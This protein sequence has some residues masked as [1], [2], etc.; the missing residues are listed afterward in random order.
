MIV[1]APGIAVGLVS[2]AIGVAYRRSQRQ[3]REDRRNELHRQ[4]WRIASNDSAC[5][6]RLV[7]T[8]LGVTTEEKSGV[9]ERGRNT[10]RVTFSR[11]AV[12]EDAV[13]RAE[14][15]RLGFPACHLAGMEPDCRS[16]RLVHR[17][18]LRT[19]HQRRVRFGCR[20]A[21]RWVLCRRCCDGWT[22]GW[23][24]NHSRPGPTARRALAVTTPGTRTI[25]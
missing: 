10:A 3:R 6:G 14:T 25:G 11:E 9:L 7:V 20:D 22:A 4:R 24:A 16:R 19:P 1:F 5:A 23:F 12:D 13:V 18:A 17:C 21:S 2:P 15:H 8:A